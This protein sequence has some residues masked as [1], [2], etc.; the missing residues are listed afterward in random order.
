MDKIK[1]FL[2]CFVPTETCNLRCHYCY[3]TQYRKFNAK[4]ARFS[5]SPQEIR[6][7]LSKERLGG[8]CLFNLC[9]GG[10]T[11]LSE[12]VLPIAHELIRE[13]HYVMIVT[14]G[15]L[16]NR[17]E[18]VAQWPAEDLS[19]LFFKFSFHFLEM[20]R[21]GWTER[22]FS[23][24]QMMKN[25][26]ASFT[27]EITPSDELIPYIDEIKETCMHYAGAL[28]HV[29]V[30]RDVTTERIEVLSDYSFDEYKTI[31]DTFDSELFRFKSEIFY[32][33]RKEFCYAGDWSVT[34]DFES[35]SMGQ[36]YNRKEID[37]IYRDINAPLHFE[38]VGHCCPQPHC[39]N[40]HAFLAL[41]DIPDLITPTY[42]EVRNRVCAD[43]SEWL[44]PEMKALMSSKLDESNR[45][46]SAAKKLALRGKQ[47]V[48]SE[49][50]KKTRTYQLLRRI[51]HRIMG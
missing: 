20:K 45:P 7:A 3:I 12:E 43:G 48:E 38:A 34:I 10:E 46:Y 5:H 9:A 50:L 42:A 26:G 39:Y 6:Y 32:K 37:N 24:V 40:G 17:F 25:A 21:L 22:F 15:T 2:E 47:M 41:G 31:W 19:H 8:T 1:R 14:N 36:C 18:E 16:T 33:K 23:N 51:K 29:T 28:C 44:R 49:K 27:V 11:L 30:A 4:L 13:G 35:G